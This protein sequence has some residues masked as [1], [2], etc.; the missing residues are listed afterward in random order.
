MTPLPQE[1]GRRATLLGNLMNMKRKTLETGISPH[2]CPVE[3]PWVSIAE[4]FGRKLRF[5]FTKGP[6]YWGLRKM[7]KA[8]EPGVYVTESFG[9]EYLSP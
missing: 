3:E 5:C 1:P 6:L 2:M 4:Q 7:I 9:N 8:L